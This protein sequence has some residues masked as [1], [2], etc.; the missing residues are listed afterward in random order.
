M[1]VADQ[2][3][4]AVRRF[5]PTGKLEAEWGSYG[6]GPGEFGAIAGLAVGP[7]GDVYVVDS[8]HDRVERFTPDGRLLGSFGS[9][10]SGLGQLS[11]RPGYTADEPPGG[12]ITVAGRY[13][14][15]A[16]SSNSRIERFDLD[17]SHPVVLVGG[18]NGPGRVNDPRGMA[19]AGGELYVADD[20]N[21]RIDVFGLDGRF[22]RE[23]GHAGNATGPSQFANPFGVAVHGPDV[24]VADDNNNRIVS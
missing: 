2:F 18:G 21:R 24:Y 11:L 16:D 12:A 17:G 23:A 22:L 13:V 20:G 15:V 14:Y 10:G 3:S 19:V 6:S 8:T 4:Y 9:P 5:S 1:F 7:N